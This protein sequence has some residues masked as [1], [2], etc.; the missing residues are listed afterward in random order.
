MVTAQ[1]GSA[2]DVFSLRGIKTFQGKDG[3]GLNATL[4][5]N[6]KPVC[7]L[8]DEG[9][10]GEMWFQWHDQRHGASEE[11]KR[12]NA[13]IDKRRAEIPADKVNE[14]DMNE[15]ELFDGETWINGEVDRIQNDRRFKRLCKTKTLFQVDGEIGGDSFRTVKGVGPQIRAWIDKQYAGKKVYV[16]N[17]KYAG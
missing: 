17:D 16:L 14:Y 12:F 11:E 13:F 5:R 15:R 2:T 7:T 3:H 1:K 9:C 4:L 8:L 6:G 10:G